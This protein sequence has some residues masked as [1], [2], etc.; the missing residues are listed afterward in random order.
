MKPVREHRFIDA[1][2]EL[3]AAASGKRQFDG[4]AAVFN[5]TVTIGDKFREVVAP[6]AFTRTL[7][8]QDV[9]FLYNHNAS[10]VMARSG[11][12]N[13]ELSEDSHGLHVAAELNE[14]DDDA[15][16]LITKLEDRNV[17]KMSF[18]FW[19]VNAP[20]N[21]EPE[22]AGLPIRT[23]AEVGL[24]D[25]SAVVWPAYEGTS[26]GIRAMDMLAETRAALQSRG[27]HLLDEEL[28]AAVDDAGRAA[29]RS[30][31]DLA[32]FAARHAQRV[33]RL[34]IAS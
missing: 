27:I 26:A 31:L 15:R 12:G 7:T 21:E 29:L 22:D 10:T 2:Y 6:G 1:V 33:R 25:V 16:N 30:P 23:L 18:G 14:K 24:A 17:D 11:A 13:L 8:E 9:A 5:Q 19:A 3:R 34:G 4:Y 28:D 32:A 20:I